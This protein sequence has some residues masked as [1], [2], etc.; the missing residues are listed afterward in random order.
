[1]YPWH[2]LII[3]NIV[4]TNQKRHNYYFLH[5]NHINVRQKKDNWIL[6]NGRENMNNHL[7]VSEAWFNNS[8]TDMEMALP[9]YCGDW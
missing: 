7:A 3:I 8:I 2:W 5:I 6:G 4:I 9:V 1:M